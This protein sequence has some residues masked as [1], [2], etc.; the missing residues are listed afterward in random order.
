M[1]IVRPLSAVGRGCKISLK[2]QNGFTLTE[3]MLAMVLF[4]TVLVI[5]TVG[6]LV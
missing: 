6:L 3:L 5:S 2:N 1:A 4:S